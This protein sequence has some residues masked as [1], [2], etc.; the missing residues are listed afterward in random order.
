[1]TTLPNPHPV[2]EMIVSVEFDPFEDSIRI[3]GERR[4]AEDAAFA[5]AFEDR[6]GVQ[7]RGL[8]GL[9]GHENQW[10]RRGGCMG[11]ART[12]RDTDVWMTSGGWGV[13]GR[14]EAAVFGGWVADP[15]AAA[16]RAVDINGRVLDD[17]VHDGVAIFMYAEE[18]DLQ[19]ARL[20]L[21]SADGELL[22][23]GPMT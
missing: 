19:H 16:A 2:I 3:V 13:P 22:R 8:I 23:S 6:G 14:T 20:E 15:D 1:M 21:R 9:C 11:S 10:R 18:F 17:Q 7:R 12:T 5:V 4:L